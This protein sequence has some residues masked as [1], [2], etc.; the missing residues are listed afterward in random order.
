MFQDWGESARFEEVAQ[1]YDVVTGDVDEAAYAADLCVVRM[2]DQ[3]QQERQVSA[4]TGLARTLLLVRECELP[5]G[6]P[7]HAARVT[8][9][10]AV[11]QI[12]GVRASNQLGVVV[13]ECVRNGADS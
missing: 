8:L 10:G 13:L 1:R 12:R 2:E 5:P 7:L 6:A 3:P 4:T 11:Y 9:G